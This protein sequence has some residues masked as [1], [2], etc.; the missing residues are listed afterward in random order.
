MTTTSTTPISRQGIQPKV[1]ADDEG[2][3]VDHCRLNEGAKTAGQGFPVTSA[4]LAAG[5]T[6]YLSRTPRSRSQM[7]AMPKKMAEKRALCARM[8]A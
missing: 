1:N 7:T 6:R 5:L 4:L 3:G 2:D 8:P